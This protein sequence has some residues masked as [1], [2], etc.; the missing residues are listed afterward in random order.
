M[1]MNQDYIGM[2]MQDLT[3]VLERDLAVHEIWCEWGVTQSV[4]KRHP[5]RV[6]CIQHEG[7]CNCT[8]DF[9]LMICERCWTHD[10]LPEIRARVSVLEIEGVSE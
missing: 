8:N 5:R 7:Q 3:K 2:P 10:V 9:M 4:C 6:R 1:S